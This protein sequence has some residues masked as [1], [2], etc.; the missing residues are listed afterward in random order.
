EM[1]TDLILQSLSEGYNQFV[2][3]YN[4][5][6]LDKQLPEMLSMLRTAE[7]ILKKAKPSSIL[8]VHNGKGKR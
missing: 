5:N 1:A 3:N 8:M 6:E 2:M 4:M 7:L